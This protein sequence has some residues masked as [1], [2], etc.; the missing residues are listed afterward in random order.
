[1]ARSPTTAAGDMAIRSH[2]YTLTAYDGAVEYLGIGTEKG[3]D[4]KSSTETLLERR[5]R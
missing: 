5:P 3:V 4:D 2:G 1:M